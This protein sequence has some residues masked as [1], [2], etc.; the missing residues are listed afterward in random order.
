MEDSGRT[1]RADRLPVIAGMGAITAFGRGVDALWEGVVSGKT[2][3][4]PVEGH[5]VE[6]VPE[7]IGGAVP[8]LAREPGAGNDAQR[9]PTVEFALTAAREAIDSSALPVTGGAPG[10]V[11]AHRWGVVAGSCNGG[12]QTVE[13]ALRPNSSRGLR[14]MVV[15]SPQTVAEVLS[16]EFGITGPTYSVNTACASSAHAMGHAAEMIRLGQVDVVLVGGSD[17][18]SAT[19]FAGFHQLGALS[20]TPASPYSLGRNGLS[21][22]EGSGM[23]VLAARDVVREAD[24]HVLAHLLGYGFS[25]DGHHATA[26]HPQGEGA[27][28]AITAAIAMSGLDP[29]D[30]DYVNGHGTGTPKN[31]PAESNA[32]RASLSEAARDIPLSSSKSMIGHLLGAAGAVEAIISVRAMQE[33]TL[34]PTANLVALDPKCGLDPVPEAR[35]APLRAVLSNNFAFG[36]ANATL[37]L[38]HSAIRHPGAAPAE[39]ENVVITGMGVLTPAGQSPDA[40]WDAFA[41]QE[42]LAP[43]GGR[44][45]RVDFDPDEYT[46]PRERRRV[47]G[48]GLIALASARRALED[49]GLEPGHR[50]GVVLGTGSGPTQSLEDFAVPVIESGPEAGSPGVFPNTVYNAA[51]GQVAQILGVRGPTSTLTANHAAGAT[52][53]CVAHDLLASGQADAV[54]CVAAET[55]APMAERVYRSLPLLGASGARY[56]LTEAGIAFVLERGAHAR[57]RGAGA[58]GTLAGYGMAS[59]ALGQGRWDPRGRGVERAMRSALNGGAMPSTVWLNAAGIASV[60]GP[61]RRALSRFTAELG[62]SPALCAPKVLLGEPVGAGAHL[63]IALALTGARRGEGT[64]DFLVNSSSLGGGHVSL[65]LRTETE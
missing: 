23:L 50:V 13:E 44:V 52:A 27:A 19:A 45:L 59:D 30:I 18:F 7:P 47:D 51:A 10:A 34:P 4:G 11:P 24:G 41:D 21:L 37:A 64:G 32:V 62:F 26:P 2:A 38:A 43:E 54:V 55:L 25:A 57:E 46:S 40:L 28:R 5:L 29:Q 53:L 58:L 14:D 60:D 31:D 39:P 49:A 12:L 9:D 17:A 35:P 36:G 15:V 63:S 8:D 6:G 3:I 20:A 61:E 22:G 48:Q 42:G 65:L 56:S 33:Q 16:A 1:V